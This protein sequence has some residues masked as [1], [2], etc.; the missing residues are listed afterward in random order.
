M[1][2]SIP[3]PPIHL[4][5]RNIAVLHRYIHTSM[6]RR[7][8]HLGIGM[9]QYPH[10]LVVCEHP[11]ISQD[12]LT[13]NL[14]YNKSSVA[15]ALISLEENGFLRRETAPGDKRA[16]QIYPTDKGRRAKTVIRRELDQVTGE[17]TAG[18]SPAERDTAAHLLLRM[19]DNAAL[20]RQPP[21]RNG[22][23]E[24]D[25]PTERNNVDE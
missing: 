1:E 7:L 16:Y 10:L 14:L 18:L 19:A 12:K 4:L 21:N 9:G 3:F 5:G 11:G 15:R 23:G 13:G 2:Q 17:F 6:A 25:A 20:D 8:A 24:E 22:R